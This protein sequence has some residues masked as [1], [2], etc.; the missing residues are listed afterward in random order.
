[1]KT[2]NTVGLR[3]SSS[4]LNSG[5]DACYGMKYTG[6]CRKAE[7]KGIQIRNMTGYLSFI[8][9]LLL[10]SLSVEA[11]VTVTPASGGTGISA[12][13]AANSTTAQWTT[14]GNIVID[15]NNNADLQFTNWVDNLIVFTAPSGWEFNPGVGSVSAASGDYSGG[16][17]ITVTFTTITLTLRGDNNAD[18]ESDIITVSG[19]QV[20][21]TDGGAALA[22]VVNIFK[23]GGITISG[24]TNNSTNFGSL[25]QALGALNRL[26]VTLPGQTFTD[27]A[28]KAASGNSGSVTN[29]TAGVSFN[30]VSLTATDQ[31]FNII[32]S[33]T[34]NKTISYSGPGS[35][36]NSP[37]YTNSVYFTIGQST[38]TIPLLTE[39]TKAETTAITA[40]DGSV[41]GT[42]SLLIVNAG[43]LSNFLV[44]AA[45][46][47]TIVNQTAGIPFAIR[48]IA[49]DANNNIVTSF[50]GSG[51]TVNI[52]AGGGTLTAGS[53]T[54]AAFTNG[55]LASH[56]VTVS[57]GASSVTLT[58]TRTSGGSET[59]TSNTFAV[60]NPGP[61][62]SNIAPDTKCEGD[63]SFT[64]TVNGTGFVNGSIV[65]I[66]GNDR[67]TVFGSSTSLTATIAAADISSP[68]IK[69]I[70][71]FN[72]APGGGTSS[73]VQLTVDVKV[74]P[75][76]TVAA[77]PNAPICLSSFVTFTATAVNTGG[78]TVTYTFKLNGNTVQSSG[79]NTVVG[80]GFADGDQVSC[81]ISISG[82]YCVTGTSASS[83]VITMDVVA[84][85]D[86]SNLSMSA[87]P[88]I[89]PGSQTG[90][91]VSSSS[92][93]DGTYTVTYNLS[94]ANT[95]NGNTAT[96]T[97]SSGSGSFIS[98]A[99]PLSGATT[100]TIT[101]IQNST[102]CISNVSSGNTAS[103][104]VPV[105]CQSVT[106]NEPAQ[107][108]A[109]ISGTASICT[110]G[111]TNVTVTLSGGTQP[112]SV[113]WPGG[114]NANITGTEPY[115]FTIP[116]SAGATYNS[117]NV[118]VTDANS[119]GANVSG[120][121]VVTVDPL[122]TASAGGSTTI[123]VS[124]TA[125]V[126]GA[127]ASNGTISWSEN[128]AGSITGGGSTVS[129][130]YTPAAGDI[131][132]TVTLTMTVTSTNSCAPATATAT[133]SVA[134]VADPTVNDPSDQDVSVGQLTTAVNFS[135]TG[136]SYTW[137][138]DNTAI[139]LAAS[140]T[141][142]IGA[143]TATNPGSTDIVGN[144]TVTPHNAYCSGPT[145]TFSITVRACPTI[146][147]HPST[148]GETLCQNATATTLSITTTGSGVTYKWFSN[149]TNSN[150]GG[151][152]VSTG[153]S[154]YTPSTAS[155]GT[156]YYYCEATIG[157]CTVKSNVSGAIVVVAQP[158]G[159]TINATS[160][161]LAAV[162]EGAD[163]SATFN[164]GSGGVGCSD[165]YQYSFDGS[166]WASYTAGSAISTTGQVGNTVRIQ[167]RRANC[168]SGAGC[169]GTS[170]TT[171]ASWVVN[172]QPSGPTL[173]A[174]SPNQSG[175]C[176]GSNASA[177][178]NVG[179]G[180]VGC[181]DQY[182]YSFDGSNWTLYIVGNN[183]STTGQAGNTLSIQGRRAACSSGAGCTGTSWTTL[184]TWLVDPLPVVYT[185]TG[186][187]ICSSASGNGTITLS[188]SQTG[189]SYQLK[190]NGGSNVQSAKSGSTGNALTWTGVATANG[191]YV[192]ATGPAPTN[193]TST[194]AAA[195]VAEVANPVA[196]VL[197]G[198]TICTSPGGNG[199][200]SSST[201]Q[202]GVSYQLYNGAN[203][204]V[205]SP[206]IGNGAGLTWNTLPAGTG[207]YVIGS[208]STPIT[209]TSLSNSVNVATW[210]NP[211]ASIS[212]D[213]ADVI[214]GNT[215]VLNGNPA[216]GSGTY[217]THAWTGSTTYLLPTNTV[218][219]TFGL[220]G[221]SIK[222]PIGSYNLVY[223]V[224]DNN[225]CIG[226]DG[227][228]V[229]VGKRTLT[230]TAN[231][232]TRVYNCLP[233]QLLP[234]V[235]YS[236]FAPGENATTEG[237]NPGYGGTF[238]GAV[239]VGSY[240]IIPQGLSSAK[241]TFNYVTGYLTVNPKTVT[242]SITANNKCFDG[243][244]TATLSA[245]SVSGLLCTPQDVVT[246]IVTAAD[247][248]NANA[249]TGKTVTATGL[250][251]GGANAGNYTLG[252]VTQVTT[253]ATIYT[254]PTIT[255]GANPA[256]CSGTTSASL[257]YSATTDSPNEYTID[258]DASAEGQLFSDV[259]WSSLPAS[260]I[261]LTVPGAATP[262]T[263]NGT[264]K[265][266]NTTTGCE[267][268]GYAI[269][270]TIRPTPTAGISGDVT[271]C[272][273]GSAPNITFTNN[274]ALP[275]TITYNING[276]GQ[277]TVDVGASTT[278][279]V[280]APTG[281]A[282]SF[283]YNLVSV[284]YQTSPACSN[285][286]TGTATVTVRP[287][288]T[289]SI[290]GT[291]TVCK[292][293]TAPDIT[294][295]NPMA[296]AVTITYNINGS[297][298]TTVDVGANTT[299]TVPA[300]T[301]T[302]GT[303][304]Y[305]LVSVAY[306][307]SPTC[308]NA[309]TGTATVTVNGITA[310][311]I[312]VA[313]Q[314]ICEET[315]PAAFT[316]TTPA[317]GSATP[318]HQ[319]QVSTT[320]CSS[321]FTDLPGE[322]GTSYDPPQGLTGN[323]YYYRRIDKSTVNGIECTAATNCVTLSISHINAG[324][325]TGNQ[326]ICSG[327]DPVVF[328]D[329]WGPGANGAYIYWW[330]S[331]TTDCNSG[332]ADISGSN[333]VRYYDVPA[334]LTQ[335]TYFRRVVRN[336]IGIL[337][338]G[339]S[340]CITVTVNPLP[341]ASVSGTTAVCQNGSQPSITF[342]G[343]NGTQEYT[344]TYNINGGGNQTVSTSGSNSITV[345][346]P[347][348]TAG[349][350]NYNL[351]SVSDGNT[352]SQAQTGTATVTV[353]PLPTASISGSTSVC[354]N[355]T[356]PDITFTGANG[357]LEY[358]FTY[359]INGGGNQ[360][361][362]T[363]GSNS[364]TVA[365]PTG[366]PGNYVYSLVSVSDGNSCSQAQTGSATVTV[367]NAVNYGTVASGDQTICSGY[368]P[369]AMSVSGV[370]GSGSFSYQWYYQAGLVSCPTGSSTSGWTSLGS[371]NG[372]N[373]AT[374]TPAAGITASTTY[375]CF[376]TPGGTPT[377]G[378]AT[379]AAGCR[380]VT[381]QSIPTLSIDD[382]TVAEN[383]AGGLATFTISLSQAVVCDVDVTVN[384]SNGTAGS[385][386]FTAVS[387]VVKTITAGNTSVTVD[388]AITNETIL[389]ADET[390]YVNLSSPVNAAI[391]D[392]QGLGTITND[393]AAAVTIADVSGAEDGGAITV[394]LA[395]D[396]AVQ[397]G[398][399][400]DV[401]TADGTATTADGDY[402]AVSGQTI[403]F[404][405]TLGETQ[406]FTV[407][408]TIDTKL[409]ADETIGLSMNNLAGTS[410]SVDIT[411]GATLTITNDDAAA[412]TIADVSG[413]EDGGAITVTLALDFAVQG[414]FTVDV[415]TADG[416]ATTADGDY[417]AVSGQTITFAGT[418]GETQTFTVLPTTDTKLEANET[419]LLSMTNLAGTSLSVDITDGATLTITNDDAAA[420]TIADVSGLEDGGAITVTLA[421][422]FAVQGGFTVD[423]NTADG[424]AT[425]ADGDYTAVSGQTIT[426]AGTLGET[427]TF[428]VLPTTDTKLEA[429][430]TVLLSMT[431]LAGTSLSV[432][433]TDG[434]TLTITNDDAAAV[435]IADV[436]GL[437][438]GGAITVTLALDFAVQ[439]GF[440]VDVNTADGTA[441]T[442]DGDYTAVSGQTI[443]FAGTLGETQ[444]FT[445]TP[446]IDTKLEADETIGLS[447][448]NLAGTSLSVDIT[449]GATLTITNDDAAAVTIAD[450]SGLE[451]G[452]AI[453]VTLALDFA[454]QGG[455][456]VDVNTADG[457]ATTADG[458]Y[459]AVSGQ[460]ITFA[461]TL[462][463]TQTFTVTP[464][465]D[466]KLE[467]DETIGLSMTN[468]AGTSLSVDI[469][470]GA[471][472]TITNDDAAAVTIADVSGLEDGGAIT[473][474]LALDF[475]VQ[476]GFTVDVNTADGTATTADGDYT[477]VTSQTITFAGTLGETQTF[478]VT[479]TI[480]TKLEADE[481][482]GLS[483]NNL[484]GTSLS[485]DITDGAT[486]T[487]TNDDAAAVTIADVSGLEDGGAITVTLALDFAVQGGFTVDVN[488]A[489]G[490]ATTVDGDYTAV[491]SQTITFAGTLGE[492]QTFTVTPTIDTKLEADETIGLSMTNLA[493][494][495]L[496]V[497]I[498]DG[499]TL[500]ITNDDAAAVTIADVS[501]AED[502]GAITVTL[503]LDYAVQG[504]FT[505]D[506]NTA[507]G[508]A[509]TADGDYT[510]VSGQTITFAGTLGET[511]T[512]TVTPTIDTKLEA[513][514]T[515][516]LSMNNLAG[517]SLSVDITDGA[518]LT[519]TNDDAAAVTI[520]DVSGLEDGGAITVTLA[521]DFAV[522][523]GFTVDVNTA[524]GTATTA[525]GDYT[526]VSGQT[527][528]FAGTLG[529]T[530]TFTVLPTTDTKL[531]A[532]ETVLLSMTNLAGTS[533]SVDITDGATLTITN[534]DA[535]AVTIADV[536]GLEDGGAI[537]VTL[538]LD[539]AVQGGFTV[540][541]N[542]ADGTATTAD[543]DYTAVS[544]QTITFAGTLGETQTFTV[545]PTTDTKLEAN[546]TVLLS[547]TNL[548]GTS[549]SVDI[550]DGATL[551]ITNDDAAAVTIADVSGAED[552]GAITVTLALDF[553]VQGGF[554][555][556]V[557]TADGTATTA[558]GDY[559]AVSGQTITF[560]GTLGET[561]T[562]T[563]T[564]TI[565][566]KLE[567]DETIGL[568]MNNLAGT[569]LSVDITDGAT[570][571]ITND[572]AAAVT[573]ADVSGLE[574]GG[575]ITVTLA[576]DF[577]VQGG[578]T[579]D[580]NT[581]DGTATTAD[582]DY[583]AVSGQTI[584]FAGTLGETQTF[585]VTPTIDTKLEADE[586]IGLSMNNLAGTSLSV[587]ITD[588]ATLTITND[589]AAA[590][591][592]ADVSGLED[593]GAITV[594]LA[595]DF[596]V[597][598]GFTVDV[599]TADGTATTA[600]GDYTA[601]TSQTI[602]F[603]G[604]L[605]ETQ[606]FT[607]TPTIDTK[608]EADETIGLSMNNL[609]GTSLS[610]DITDGATLT[611]TNDDAAA[612]TIADV[613][614][615]EDGGAIT[616]TL[617]LD[618]AVQGGFT[619]DV[620]TADGT[621]TTVDGDY[622][623][624]TSQTITFAGTLG[625]T[626]TFTVTPTI[627]TKL[628]ADETIGLS[629]NNLAGTSLSVDITDGAT[630]TITNDDAAAVTIADVSGAE[631]G[632][633]ITVTLA[634]D[635]A[636]Q[637][638][639]TV[640]VNT[641]DGT[642]TTA[643]GDYTAVSGQTITFAGTLGETQTFTV[644]PTTDTKL[645]ANETVLLS[646]TNLAG[647]SLSV[648]ITDGATLT[649][650]NDDAAAVTIADVSG[651]EDGGA[652]TVTLALDFAV[653]GGFTVDVNTADG[654]ATTADGDYTAV[655]GQTITFAGTLGET[656][657]FTVLPTTDTKLEA[658][659]T[660]LLSMTNLAG[661]SLSVDI[662]DGATLTITN[663]DAAAVTIADV[664]GLEDGGAI[665]VT[666]ALDF[667]VQG[668]FTVD[669]NTADGTA[670]TVDGDYTAVTSQTITFAGTLGETQ[671]FTVTPTIDTKLEAD[672]TIG[673]SMNNLAGTSLSVDITDGAT[674]TITNDDAAAVTIADVSGAEDGGAITVTLAL[675]FAVQGGFTVDVNTA[676]GTATTADG[677][678][679][680]V[681]GQTITFA[682]TL[683]ET[684]TFTVLPTTDTKLEANETV[685]LSM[686]NLA[687]TSL[688]V[689]ITD[690]A[691]LTI[692]NDDAAA[693]TIADVSGLEDGGAITVTL[694]L[695]FAVQG[696]FTV[697]VNTA[698]GTATTAD[699]DY[700]AV[701]GQTIT[702]AGTLGETQTFTVLPTTDTKLE[703]NETVLLS[704]TNLAGTSLSVDITDG[705]TLTITNDDAAAVT[706]ADVS[707]LEDGGAITVTLALDF[708][709][710]GGFTVDVNTADGTATTADGD[711]TAVTSQ[712]ITFAGR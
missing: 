253:T 54:T 236:G 626:Q 196:L 42:S 203:A 651:L 168:T 75:S 212:P 331:S 571:T 560:A 57:P 22:S 488:T 98:T 223:T 380:Q 189:V 267:S 294:F 327:G 558:D 674:L 484:A 154:S 35:G 576:L 359:T 328:G 557:N 459:T 2:S 476:G 262:A 570:L 323:T 106:L 147:A 245:Q 483:M 495:S 599:N 296:L 107:L 99:L 530:Q 409:E 623:A 135:G 417:T 309:I 650:T 28:T 217:S 579:V 429:N 271:V 239:N 376:V 609:A 162:C 454:V 202:N 572:D 537:T 13:R 254:P 146:T 299:A 606:T 704:M 31:F 622:T 543:G 164:A 280:P 325:I 59:G 213:P 316:E 418:L 547:M 142:N 289:A 269:S 119:C 61:T 160:P 436:S 536:S 229:S 243:T 320:S 419:V 134:V 372:A 365:V 145:Q 511:Q 507:D 446:T 469:T 261:S 180:G 594:T 529:E 176:A 123:C 258:W 553:A 214:Y 676:D 282:G 482:I 628:E 621:A 504:G 578:F 506:V 479:P 514:E 608:L 385:S 358:T 388:V 559:T 698:D 185:L 285:A 625:E 710:Q 677:D 699:G 544:G 592:I 38:N 562:F 470:D 521:L 471:T 226:T 494:T 641:A 561:Q 706:I 211:T 584:T 672:E 466:T 474:T 575:A 82:A 192:V 499:A 525:D 233:Y 47:G 502:G 629:M 605:G 671:T 68:G 694:A 266:R 131:G 39:L 406:T 43:A 102:G 682:G 435:T 122:P 362:S 26:V 565:D 105:A 688:S 304:A 275:V 227:I 81:D 322:T 617:A 171:L 480:D 569:S 347:T 133:Y 132:N 439:G 374:Y 467:A 663:D 633:A 500:T 501:G 711:Y 640:D 583:T 551:T 113:S 324:V 58:A 421:L 649:I 7:A 695:D 354:L 534:D 393:D 660:V 367:L 611:I 517:T 161:N 528:T 300:P 524:D 125:T 187:T 231:S 666:L 610:V 379:W 165:E 363:S 244:T 329:T 205:G 67:S 627:D 265:V 157:T 117:G 250:S 224:T 401:N 352:C 398:F 259:A 284:A 402:T 375:A 5:N 167:G 114:S 190:N 369:N 52:T 207:Y 210:A 118:T 30:I 595:L 93:V 656:Q 88:P 10:C 574:D 581:A 342:T 554:T 460:T 428:T 635:Y 371:T 336:N 450:V 298:Q 307:S 492:T 665:T 687:G 382:V 139:G 343:A 675:D 306:Q 490:T 23:T 44:D 614:G 94:G 264:L 498:T 238:F 523:G 705:A 4:R 308:S 407:T 442:A 453:T 90:V 399:T 652:I 303:F 426:F 566:T 567:A 552:G 491:T 683:G 440:T 291:I 445:V 679:T 603:A 319:W 370:D 449:D 510:A 101:S 127:S 116:V 19:I 433:I 653:Q 121:A 144:I 685:L 295:T 166:T 607:V 313:T 431:N 357:T 709:V 120:S 92:L 573:I 37:T 464:T 235:T 403:T 297:N 218:N 624:V 701:S 597:Q 222:A 274:M 434:A 272:Q 580:V 276:S 532:N 263:Y 181:D 70:T 273:G 45:G 103:F 201:S 618:F 248:D 220:D 441:T 216:G 655:S 48:V 427:Q 430:E 509:T 96:L 237:F 283:A 149:N 340:N 124:Q 247:F 531:E 451:D 337:C 56:S 673:L 696:G 60:N 310:G 8:A 678:Y 77:V 341:T 126:S 225:G 384:T 546:E 129:P 191:Y 555:V 332:F 197:T 49:W 27:A 228:T 66:N 69:N 392:A 104:T 55:G 564:P 188:N 21:A 91:Q 353:Y 301:G 219:P 414:G 477:A 17:S 377:C 458:D 97:M 522:Q 425:T 279:T 355:G 658:N 473:V 76:V 361:V 712:T 493:G 290:S 151:T 346:A 364:A 73:A 9:M 182:Q 84:D 208:I 487:I 690:G 195:D 400:V 193:C 242:P 520:A 643:D 137:V 334:G 545:L 62:L 143:F 538:A 424:T 589:D 11:A 148:S 163:V 63:A 234:G 199:T 100:V 472:L 615:L 637:G 634:L 292:D 89:C 249:G 79:S 378:T 568:S 540:D 664:S 654:T 647:T 281:T 533:L 155:I 548:A 693:V 20:R 443:T 457:T 620:N 601:V 74:T 669:V 12:D 644:L 662:T 241:Y 14:L 15:E 293:G 535:A 478:T 444:T 18:N 288:P 452:G 200:I 87:Y 475:A 177:T 423:V 526:A 461:G 179:S 140:G 128:G 591:T 680:A 613:S 95:S 86:V 585:T 508:T 277:T 321:G 631:D 110:G 356:Q 65:R 349:T 268:I 670:T 681:S 432:D 602:T 463:E 184:A 667:A 586:T 496:S 178:F 692:T 16:S 587:D 83:N 221:S 33:Y 404:A 542:T 50:N 1:M 251:L 32:T 257:S 412:V 169:T 700:T 29:Q 563:V 25:S 350:F 51:N 590:V 639:F 152:Q 158:T 383:V 465:I 335:T 489:D 630:L 503:A 78:G 115:A 136:T 46:G 312:G 278:G 447:M 516:G 661:T 41:F 286:I 497:D 438:D 389:E 305:N 270:V 582:G 40:S 186:S 72:P 645:E 381:V 85:P 408:P 612:V 527:I 194:T 416:T 206:Q 109:V 368:T 659:E 550:T 390:Y 462:G 130:T 386:D 111:S 413:L 330:Q 556:D 619:V 175:I 373:T 632:G 395:L 702:F 198:S 71:V 515:I 396:Y 34:G 256:V 230:V 141:G 172:S 689:D 513:D 315:D 397:G 170:W 314:L 3:L 668:G 593:G 344:F 173:N 420:V 209:C 596:A 24:V 415:N 6:E 646:M 598:G 255:L 80:N 616:V 539:F 707:G 703:A 366:T 317:S 486:L 53:G 405:G 351:I 468:L 204:T 260:P 422:D 541:V 302:A 519:I 360:T 505:V 708:A 339:Y 240:S 638:G 600:D 215:Q 348:G 691:T 437:E 36:L 549:L 138:N 326:T 684:Q 410:L 481:T 252:A 159:P 387:S 333:G 174:K 311:V 485:V 456:T 455:F 518:T 657:T 156:L 183:I 287:T 112:W 232:P 686:T 64:I 108:T 391:L 697:D 150:I 345:A 338:Y 604:T 394:T 246:L 577:A 588:G 448:N 636:V 318:T 512:F 411:D 648:D 153:S 642:A